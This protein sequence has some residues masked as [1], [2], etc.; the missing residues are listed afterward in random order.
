MREMLRVI[1]G[2][3]QLSKR[4]ST[5][6]ALFSRFP[7]SM[8]KFDLSAELLRMDLKVRRFHFGVALGTLILF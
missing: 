5:E 3:S 1:G 8:N 2:H 7:A 6:K 4:A